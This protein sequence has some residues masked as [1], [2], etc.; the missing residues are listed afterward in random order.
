ML[1]VGLRVLLGSVWVGGWVGVIS[2]GGM[3]GDMIWKEESYGIVAQWC[4]QVKV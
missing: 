3:M 4:L 2:K 1:H